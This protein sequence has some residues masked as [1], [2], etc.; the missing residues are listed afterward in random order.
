MAKATVTV[1]L[2]PGPDLKEFMTWYQHE[3]VNR[4][5]V[6]AITKTVNGEAYAMFVDET[7]HVRW[8]AFSRI[9]DGEAMGW[10]QAFTPKR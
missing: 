6:E 4:P 9:Q 7:N 2:L 3:A 1:E 5:Q 8:V 10:R